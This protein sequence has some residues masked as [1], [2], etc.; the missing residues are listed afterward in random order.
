VG[1]RGKGGLGEAWVSADIGRRAVIHRMGRSVVVLGSNFQ[2]SYSTSLW[3]HGHSGL[4]AMLTRQNHTGNTSRLRSARPGSVVASLETK[5]SKV[6][7][8]W[9]P[10]SG[11]LLY[12]GRV[13][14]EK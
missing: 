9:V 8:S 11:V 13:C 12:R 2:V 7:L 5:A 14:N 4:C 1:G 3:G 6:V 10:G